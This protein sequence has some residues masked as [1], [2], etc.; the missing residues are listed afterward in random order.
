MITEFIWSQ[1]FPF[2]YT[3]Y[4]LINDIVLMKIHPPFEFNDDVKPVCLPTEDMISNAYSND[5]CFTSGWG[6]TRNTLQDNKLLKIQKDIHVLQ[7]FSI[8]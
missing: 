8:S 6:M 2:N 5:N 4:S 3:G 7:C 1:E